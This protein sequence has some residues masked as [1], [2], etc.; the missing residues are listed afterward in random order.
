MKLDLGM[1]NSLLKHFLKC[2][3]QQFFSSVVRIREAKE[4]GEKKGKC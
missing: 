2:L 3:S 1:I 4:A